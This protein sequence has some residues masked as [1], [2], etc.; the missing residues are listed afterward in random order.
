MKGYNII[1]LGE[2][3]TPALSKGREKSVIISMGIKKILT[4]Y[5]KLKNKATRLKL[6]KEFS[7]TTSTYLRNFKLK[8]PGIITI[9]P[10][11]LPFPR[12]PLYTF[13]TTNMITI[14]YSTNQTLM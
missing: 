9:Y 3:L 14:L 7:S 5:L 4:T 6:Q 10:P 12:Q 2:I 1:N 11:S 13:L 8:N